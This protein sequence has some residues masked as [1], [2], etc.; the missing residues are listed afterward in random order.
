[1]PVN[2]ASCHASLPSCA[3]H[4]NAVTSKH[5]ARETCFHVAASRGAFVGAGYEPFVSPLRCWRA[6]RARAS[7]SGR[8]RALH[9][10]SHLEPGLHSHG[11]DAV[12]EGL[13]DAV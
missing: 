10:D 8:V 11:R 13:S 3:T 6:R 1:M 2:A 7:V 5:L 12:L 4:K 9:Q